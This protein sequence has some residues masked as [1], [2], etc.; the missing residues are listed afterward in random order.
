MK[1]VIDGKPVETNVTTTHMFFYSLAVCLFALVWKFVAWLL[2]FD[3]T[4]YQALTLTIIC[5]I[6]FQLYLVILFLS[7]LVNNLAKIRNKL[8]GDDNANKKV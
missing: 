5:G 1:L 3:L 7:S 2:N 4:F 6:V 8:T